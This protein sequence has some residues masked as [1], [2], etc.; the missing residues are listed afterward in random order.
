MKV[1]YL[2]KFSKDLDKL[3]QPKDRAAIL[4][5]IEE[6]KQAASLACASLPPPESLHLRQLAHYCRNSGLE[7]W[8]VSMVLWHATTVEFLSIQNGMTS[9]MAGTSG[10]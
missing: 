2:A 1:A 3:R 10:E 4:R 7:A 8:A 9:S 5:T 6:V